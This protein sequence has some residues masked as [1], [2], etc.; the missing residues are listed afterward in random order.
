MKSHLS[1]FC[2][3]SDIVVRDWG[4]K[5]FLDRMHFVSLSLSKV[6]TLCGKKVGVSPKAWV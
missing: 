3:A 5:Y 6:D 4:F 1:L 2:F